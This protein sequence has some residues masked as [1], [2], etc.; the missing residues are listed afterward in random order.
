MNSAAENSPIS[1]IFDFP[2]SYSTVPKSAFQDRQVLLSQEAAFLNALGL[3]SCFHHEDDVGE[4]STFTVVGECCSTFAVARQGELLL[5]WSTKTGADLGSFS[6]MVDVIQ[7]IAALTSPA[8]TPF[9]Q[10][11]DLTNMKPTSSVVLLTP[12]Q[13][14]GGARIHQHAA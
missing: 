1:N 14:G 8:S 5:L 4:F 11:L 6:S 2:L 3:T 12:E 13:L 10:L 9:A 7:K